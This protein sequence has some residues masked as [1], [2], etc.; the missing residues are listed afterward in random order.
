M[1]VYLSRF[2]Y[3]RESWDA[4]MRDPED[5]SLP[6]G[7]A[8]ES[9]GGRLIGLWYAFGD[10]DGYFLYEAPDNVSAAALAVAISS[11]EADWGSL[12]TTVLLSLDEAIDAFRRAQFVRYRSPEE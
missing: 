6:L 2:R 11:T 5:R 10:Y 1:A 3:T 8:I 7:M 12:E 9:V 4:L